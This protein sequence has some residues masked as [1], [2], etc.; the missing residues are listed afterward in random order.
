MGKV[1]KFRNK[2]R[3]KKRS[4]RP[5]KSNTSPRKQRE[6]WQVAMVRLPFW[7]DNPDDPPAFRPWN[8]MAFSLTQDLVGSS[9]VAPRGKPDDALIFDAIHM[10]RELCGQGPD[11]IEISDPGMELILRDSPDLATVQIVH[12][13]TLAGLN[14]VVDRMADDFDIDSRIIPP[15]LSV[16][17]LTKEDLQSFA[18]AF[19]RFFKA[20]PWTELENEDIIR[21]DS[22]IPDPSLRHMTVMGAAGQEFGL[23]MMENLEG[24]HRLGDIDPI[25]LLQT[26]SLWSVSLFEAKMLHFREQDL[27]EDEGLPLFDNGLIPAAVRYGPKSRLRRASPEVLAFIA[28]VLAALAETTPEDLDAESWSRTVTTDAGTTTLEFSLLDPGDPLED[29]DEFGNFPSPFF[30]ERAR[31]QGERE[32]SDEDALRGQAQ[33]L[34]YEAMETHGRRRKSLA[35]KALSLWPD[36]V[37]ALGILA[38]SEPNPD[39]AIKLLERAVETARK[40]LGKKAFTDQVGHFWSLTETRPYMRIRLALAQALWETGRRELALDHFRELLRLN[41]WDNQGVRFLF[42]PALIQE[43]RLD[44]AEQLLTDFKDDRGAWWAYT[45][46]LLTF[47]TQGDTALAKRRLTA[48]F[49]TNPHL[50]PLLIGRKSLP[51]NPPP[52]FQYGEETEAQALIL[53]LLPAWSA[54]KGAIE[55]TTKRWNHFNRE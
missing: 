19:E 28:A 20:A 12:R 51:S 38:A 21:I 11:C 13:P 55:W 31:R 50:A 4:T 30:M 34:A 45:W 22:S 35:R 49:K 46:A 29:N 39:E 40:D 36:C 26:T 27:W 7:I 52:Y 5:R 32:S 48:A 33:E 47:L 43:G 6:V 9:E 17:G 41:P 37:D 10:L 16:P 1:V 18:R 25:E 54:S 3:K 53:D 14:L 15:A 23:A 42:A 24:L 44:E 8:A 2:S